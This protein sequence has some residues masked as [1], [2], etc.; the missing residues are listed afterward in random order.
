MSMSAEDRLDI[1][2]LFARYSWAY[3]CGEADAYAAV[4]TADGVLEDGQDLKAVGTA[5]NRDAIQQFFTLRGPN[6]WQ[7]HNAQ[8]RMEAN[9]HACTVWSYWAL[10]E[11][12]QGDGTRPPNAPS[13]TRHGRRSASPRR[14]CFR[15]INCT[16]SWRYSRASVAASIAMLSGRRRR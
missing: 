10:L 3:D 14:C 13:V 15:L 1:F 12:R 11:K 16:G 5:Q 9:G 2:D 7:H 8:L 4:F 6:V